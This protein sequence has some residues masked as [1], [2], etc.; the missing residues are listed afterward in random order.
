ALPRR[1]NAILAV[2]VAAARPERPVPP[3]P[4]DELALAAFRAHLAGRHRLGTLLGPPDVPAVGVGRGAGEFSITATPEP[5]VAH[6]FRAGVVQQLRL[7][8]L[9]VG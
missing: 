6:T 7:V 2:G 3:L 8:R 1:C 9:P 4:L 5:Q